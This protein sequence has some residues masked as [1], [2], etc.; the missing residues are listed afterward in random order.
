MGHSNVR[1]KARRRKVAGLA[2]MSRK[3][4]KCNNTIPTS[5]KKY[6]IVPFDTICDKMPRFSYP[7]IGGKTFVIDDK[8]GYHLKDDSWDYERRPM[9]KRLYKKTKSQVAKR[10]AL[11]GIKPF[12]SDYDLFP[13]HD[14]FR[15]NRVV[16]MEKL[17]EHKLARWIRKNPPPIQQDDEQKDLFEQQFMQPWIEARDAATERFRNNVISTYDKL[18]LTGRFKKN[19]HQYEEKVVAEIKDIG[20]EGHKINDLNLK[21]S[22]LLKKA[23]DITNEIHKK[24]ARLMC[25]NLRDHKKIHG[26]IILPKAA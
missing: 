3:F 4:T 14:P 22:K 18:T 1:I 2:G 13:K 21:T 17:V 6:Y 26:R 20:G 7:K 11:R 15:M 24:N 16:Y 19:E 9:V 10:L 12:K 25:T 8:G 23:Q 5:S